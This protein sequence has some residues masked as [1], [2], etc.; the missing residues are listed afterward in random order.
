MVCFLLRYSRAYWYKIIKTLVNLLYT[1]TESN[2]QGWN[3]LCLLRKI[4]Y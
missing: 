1:C 2:K 4:F 3:Q